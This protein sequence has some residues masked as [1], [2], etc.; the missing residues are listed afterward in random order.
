MDKVPNTK[1]IIWG[2]KV[3]NNLTGMV[4][5]MA[6]LTGVESPFLSGEEIKQIAQKREQERIEAHAEELESSEPAV[7]PKVEAPKPR[8]VTKVAPPKV[9][10]KKEE[11]GSSMYIW[12]VLVVLILLG[13]LWYLK[14]I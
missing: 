4:R 8:P 14:V 13:L 2:A 9:E 10:E 7:R 1:R 11:K 3:D 5:V 12:I 6:V